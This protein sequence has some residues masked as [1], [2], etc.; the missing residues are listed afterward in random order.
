MGHGT[1]TN[2]G[3]PTEIFDLMG[4]KEQMEALCFL[5]IIF[6]EEIVAHPK[7]RVKRED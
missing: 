5:G 4:K 1:F 2:R 7:T 3:K 6:H